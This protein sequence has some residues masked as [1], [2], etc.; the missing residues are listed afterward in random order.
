M[1]IFRAAPAPE[2]GAEA[3]A[4]Q[5]Y[6]EKDEN[7]Q[8]HLRSEDMCEVPLKRL[9]HEKLPRSDAR[10]IGKADCGVILP[11][12]AHLGLMAS[13][14]SQAPAHHGIATLASPR[15]S[16]L[17]TCSVGHSPTDMVREVSSQARAVVL[18]SAWF[19]LRTGRQ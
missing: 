3:A 6:D 4:E 2:G 17:V 13:T 14:S 12:P 15:E 18:R 10:G 8:T 1:A 7:D 11:S 19:N 16:N 9:W 5:Q